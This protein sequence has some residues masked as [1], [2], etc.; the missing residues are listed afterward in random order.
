MAQNLSKMIYKLFDQYASKILIFYMQLNFR[1]TS[2]MVTANNHKLVGCKY[3]CFLSTTMGISLNVD[4]NNPG[5]EMGT[6]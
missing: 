1:S 5:R 3:H 6:M 4:R 2:P